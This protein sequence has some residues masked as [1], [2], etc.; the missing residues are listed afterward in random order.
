MKTIILAVALTTLG[1]VSCGILDTPT[2]VPACDS[3]K[4]DSVKVDTN[5]IGTAIKAP[6]DT[7]H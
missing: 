2:D 6:L 7:T 3:V 5:S 1:L 4:I